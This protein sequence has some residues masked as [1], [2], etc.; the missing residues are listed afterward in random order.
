MLLEES[1]VFNCGTKLKEVESK[2]KYDFVRESPIAIKKK[3]ASK[4]IFKISIAINAHLPFIYKFIKKKK[5]KKE[6]LET[7]EKEEINKL[8]MDAI[9]QVSR[10]D[11]FSKK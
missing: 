8:F 10:Y 9:K 4:V 7:F 11:F 1:Y 3:L 2:E 5:N 6:I